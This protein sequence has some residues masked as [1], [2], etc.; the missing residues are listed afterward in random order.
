[1]IDD[2]WQAEQ[3]EP[4][5][6][7]GKHC[8]RLVTTRIASSLPGDAVRVQIDR[9]TFEQARQVL[10]WELPAMPPELTEQLLDACGKW[11]LLLR[12]T[13]RIL[14]ADLDVGQPLETA[15]AEVLSRLQAAGPAA[16]DPPSPP[17]SSVMPGDVAVPHPKAVRATIEASVRLLVR[18]GAAR[19]HELGVF[20]EDEA[21]PIDLI[22]R[23]WQTT[24]G[25]DPLQGRQLC[26]DLA[27]LSLVTL[28]PPPVPSP[29]TT[30]YASICAASWVLSDSPGSAPHCWTPPRQVFP[31]PSHSPPANPAPDRLVADGEL[32]PRRPPHHAPAGRRTHR[33]SRGGRRGPALGRGPPQTQR[34]Q[35]LRT[36]TLSRVPTEL[37]AARA[38]ALARA[39]H[40]LAPTTPE[41]SLASVLHSR[42][43]HEPCWQSQALQK[44]GQPPAAASD[45]PMAPSRSPRSRPQAH[46]DGTY[47]PGLLRGRRA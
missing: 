10:T 1:M 6:Y 12:L 26:R 29:C 19:F 3:L 2:V 35:R 43:R 23:L 4:F 42:I 21:V 18:N 7:G 36:P 45:Q 33:G 27:D 9:M 30:S 17:A 20:A 38:G 5:L 8:A 25:L 13:N 31:A 24:A 44:A 14:A 28:A 32:L 34:S 39:A 11:P 46:A 37:A 15:A 16:V 40:L 22:T 47:G 41:H